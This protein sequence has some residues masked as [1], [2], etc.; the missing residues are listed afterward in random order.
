MSINCLCPE[1]RNRFECQHE[2]T[3][4]DGYKSKVKD[5]CEFTLMRDG[6]GWSVDCWK[7]DSKGHYSINHWNVYKSTY[8]AALKEYERW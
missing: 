3:G 6:N 2:T 8:E 5:D 1:C 4:D 7:L